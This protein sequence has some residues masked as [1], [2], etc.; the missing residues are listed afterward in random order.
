M[1]L[2][3]T[4]GVAR[5]RGVRARVDAREVHA[6]LV[7]RT[8]GVPEAHGRDGGAVV[9]AH[10]HGP[11]V[12]R[13][14]LFVRGTRVAADAFARA[15]TLAV[16]GTPQVRGTIAV[17]RALAFR[18]RARQLAQLG[19]GEPVFTRA[20]CPVS[21]RHARL[22]RFAGERVARVPARAVGGARQGRRTV[23]VPGALGRGRPSG[24]PAGTAHVVLGARAH[25]AQ[26]RRAARRARRVAHVT[27]R[28][29]ALSPVQHRPAQRVQA[30]RVTHATRVDAT[31][32]DARLF[33]CTL[34]VVDAFG[35]WR[36]AS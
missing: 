25:A 35:H 2:D 9:R 36:N 24:R 23:S 29:R 15:A 4:R 27:V 20:T 7:P 18:R 21:A 5:A 16:A 1:G 34:T 14:T 19:D 28:A 13:Q 3:G 8:T 17:R 30:A 31:S 22:G 10:A 12:E 33:V 6:R 26:V 11:V 32:A